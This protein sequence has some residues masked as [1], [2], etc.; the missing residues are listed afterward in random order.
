MENFR[1]HVTGRTY[2]AVGT[3]GEGCAGKDGG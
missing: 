1:N 3:S 2:E